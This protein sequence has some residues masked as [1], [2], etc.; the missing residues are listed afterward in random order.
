MRRVPLLADMVARNEVAVKSAD[1]IYRDE[2]QE[3]IEH[4]VRLEEIAQLY[5]NESHVGVLWPKGIVQAQ[6]KQ[7]EIPAGNRPE[8]KRDLTGEGVLAEA[9]S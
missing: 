8:A 1:E 2:V 7:A 3:P 5:M 6:H 4:R 9:K